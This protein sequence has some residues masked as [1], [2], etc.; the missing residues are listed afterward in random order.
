MRKNW[1]CELWTVNL[2]L[3][4]FAIFRFEIT[5]DWQSL[6]VVREHH[7]KCYSSSKAVLLLQS[8]SKEF[9]KLI[10]NNLIIVLW[11]QM[12]SGKLSENSRKILFTKDV[13]VTVS[14]ISI[15]WCLLHKQPLESI[16]RKRGFKNIQKKIIA[17]CLR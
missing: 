2:I 5:N 4:V 6:T 14:E 3:F 10:E 11:G 7:L 17:N 9:F 16:P 1:E 8:L 15:L 13:S 12:S